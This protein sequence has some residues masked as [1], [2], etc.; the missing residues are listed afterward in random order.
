MPALVNNN[1]NNHTIISQGRS[2]LNPCARAARVYC[3][4]AAMSSAVAAHPV[5]ASGSGVSGACSAGAAR[6]ASDA[7]ARVES[8]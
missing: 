5:R 6:V 3:R 4:E 8:P 7:R 2:R 1:A